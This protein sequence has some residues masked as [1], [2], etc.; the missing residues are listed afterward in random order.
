MKTI[1]EL[2]QELEKAKIKMEEA[3]EW[4]FG[5]VGND[6]RAIMMSNRYWKLHK[7]LMSKLICTH[8]GS[9]NIGKTTKEYLTELRD[10][11]CYN[12]NKDF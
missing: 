1:K 6:P 2:G 7:Q 10:N 12:C 11:F 3:V 4:N 9:K 5:Y 8:C